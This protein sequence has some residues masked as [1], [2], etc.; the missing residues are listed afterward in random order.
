MLRSLLCFCTGKQ[1]F[2]AFCRVSTWNLNV[3]FQPNQTPKYFYSETISVLCPVK[4]V[5]W[6]ELSWV[7][8]Q[9]VLGLIKSLCQGLNGWTCSASRAV[10]NC[11]ISIKMGVTISHGSRNIVNILYIVNGTGPSIWP[12][13]TPFD[14]VKYIELG[15]QCWTKDLSKCSVPQC[16]LILW[17]RPFCHRLGV[18]LDITLKI[19]SPS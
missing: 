5:T 14:S 4:V 17:P 12:R 18:V 6:T 13:G 10:Q 9:S 19:N 7:I 3:S 11:I 8:K 16:R 2:Y 1:F 15:A